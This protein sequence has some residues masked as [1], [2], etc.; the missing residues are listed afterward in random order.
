MKMIPSSFD[1]NS[2]DSSLLVKSKNLIIQQKIHEIT[3]TECLRFVLLLTRNPIAPIIYQ[4]CINQIKQ[5]FVFQS[6]IINCIFEY[7]FWKNN[8]VICKKEIVTTAKL[9]HRCK[10]MRVFECM[11]FLYNFHHQT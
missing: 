9:L 5:T 8:G 4:P 3:T 10:I 6:G 2:Q 1:S 7:S 11:K